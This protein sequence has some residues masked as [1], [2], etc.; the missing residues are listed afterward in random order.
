MLRYAPSPYHQSHVPP[1]H[2][3]S[4]VFDANTYHPNVND[5]GYKYH[6]YEDSN[7]LDTKNFH[8]RQQ[9]LMG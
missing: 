8:T 6:Y 1:H 9:L 5:D 2:R 7:N 4:F 3:S